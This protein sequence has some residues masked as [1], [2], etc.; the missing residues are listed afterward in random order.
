MQTPTSARDW[1]RVIDTDC[2]PTFDRWLALIPNTADRVIAVYEAE[3]GAWV[4]T[5]AHEDE[6]SAP[7]HTPPLSAGPFAS[8]EEAMR[9]ADEWCA[10]WAPRIVDMP[11]AYS[12]RLCSD[13]KIRVSDT[14]DHVGENDPAL[15]PEQA[16]TLADALVALAAEVRGRARD[17]TS[18]PISRSFADGERS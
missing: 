15:S 10:R 6:E 1:K 11:G 18:A 3:P 5:T 7:E 8:A 9:V 17:C 2:I 12:L 13:G 16:L 14:K 4:A